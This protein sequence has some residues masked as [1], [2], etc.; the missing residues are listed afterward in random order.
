[1]RTLKWKLSFIP[2]KQRIMPIGNWLD[3][4]L[5]EYEV[6]EPA[7]PTTYILEVYNAIGEKFERPYILLPKATIPDPIT[8]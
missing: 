8:P 6:P 1:M 3:P 7:R 5:R 4:E 2:S